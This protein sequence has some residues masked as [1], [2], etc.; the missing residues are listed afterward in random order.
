MMEQKSN[1]LNISGYKVINLANPTHEQDATTKAYVDGI[2]WAVHDYNA[3]SNRVEYIH[4]I[5][6][7]YITMVNLA[8]ICTVTTSF[9]VRHGVHA[10]DSH[11]EH[12]WL[13]S[14]MC[15]NRLYFDG[16][17]LKDKYIQVEYKYPVTV[18]VWH[19][20]VRYEHY[21][22]TAIT[23]HWQVSNDGIHWISSQKLQTAQ[24][25][26]H[27]YNGNTHSISFPNEDKPHEGY[28]FWR[29]KVVEGKI[30]TAEK[31]QPWVSM[32]FMNLE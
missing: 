28:H 8:G 29:I 20:F 7:K 27:E 21:D 24:I 5:N 18:N 25:K 31:H 6:T 17:E 26:A 30:S 11:L 3:L 19:L 13:E 9:K 22:W 15:P 12:I 14:V 4:T 1:D 10:F 32:L 23:Y 16:Q 2:V